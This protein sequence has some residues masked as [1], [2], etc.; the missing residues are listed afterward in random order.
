[1][2]QK[3]KRY[4]AIALTSVGGA[5]A[6]VLPAHAALPAGVTAAIQDAGAQLVEAGGIVLLAMCAFW[7][8]KKVGTKLGMW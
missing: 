6:F 5:V 8:V 1:M 4:G 2:F 7:A 3:M